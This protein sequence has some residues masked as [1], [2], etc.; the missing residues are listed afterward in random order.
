MNNYTNSG[1][2]L[3]RA[4]KTI[5]LGSQT[6]SKSKVAF[7]QNA[8]PLFIERGYGSKV[9]DAD[10]NEYIDFVNGLLSI[11][12]GYCDAEINQAVVNQ[13][14]LGVTFSL[15]HKLEME[16]AEELVKL[17]PCAEMVRFGKNGSDATS[18]AIRL[19]R[20][21]TKREHVAVCG[22]HGWQDWYIGS[23]TR[24]LGV[25]ECVRALTHTFTYNDLDSLE[26]LFNEHPEQL[27]AVIMEPMNVAYPKQ[28]FLEGVQALC[29]K[30]GT[31]LIFDET[32]TGFRFDLHGAQGLFNVTPD[33][34]TFGKGM[35]NGFPISAVVGKQKIMSLMEDIFFSGTFAGE[36]MSLAATKATLKKMQ[37]KDVLTH[38]HHLGD[39]LIAELDTLILKHNAQQWLST[40]GHPAWSFI[41]IKDT[42]HYSSL[43]LKSLFIQEMCTRG[44]LIAG[45]HNLSYAHTLCD[46][47]KLLNA[48]DEVIAILVN[49]IKTQNLYT[50]FKGNLLEPV[51]KVR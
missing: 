25:P 40:A 46:I 39:K 24:N 51:F 34:A 29:Q 16:V 18:A 43:E 22:Y 30:Y 20:A 10:N 19:A 15:P 12:L 6:F 36:T 11:S 21:Y 45:S 49:T 48:Y 9:W 50:I 47:E 33:L 2:W 8:A 14:A 1:E 44:I 42:A 7:P 3:Q 27:A 26:K 5:P 4:E 31:V 32:I 13:L 38:I 28:G 41:V 37:E 17:I 23:T 35:A